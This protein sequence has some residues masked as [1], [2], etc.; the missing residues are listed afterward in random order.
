MFNMIILIHCNV[1]IYIY[2]VFVCY[3]RLKHYGTYWQLNQPNEDYLDRLMHPKQ[4]NVKQLS[5]KTQMQ[6]GKPNR[7]LD[8][9]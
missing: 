2:D 7:N 6:C 5:S 1:Y 3:W 9:V 4:K 8:W